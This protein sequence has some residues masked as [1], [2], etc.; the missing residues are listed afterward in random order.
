MHRTAVG[1]GGRGG[2]HPYPGRPGYGTPRPPSSRP[3]GALPTWPPDDSMPSGATPE[4]TSVQGV[5]L[6]NRPLYF[7]IPPM[8]MKRRPGVHAGTTS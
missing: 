2:M 5:I 6:H 3:P 8:N 4:W 1:H 7:D